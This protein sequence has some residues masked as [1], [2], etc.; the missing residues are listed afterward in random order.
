MTPAIPLQRLRIKRRS[1]AH[2]LARALGIIAG[3]VPPV[4]DGKAKNDGH[5][6]D[7]RSVN[8]GQEDGDFEGFFQAHEQAIFGYLWHITGDEQ[9]SYDLAQETFLRAWQRFDRVRRYE[10]PRAWLFRVATNLAS[11]HRRNRAMRQAA[12]AQVGMT[13]HA[14]V[15]PGTTVAAS[16]AVREALLA[17]PMKQRGALILRVVYGLSFAEIAQAFGTSEAAAKM[18]LA[19]G[20]ERFRAHYTQE[21]RR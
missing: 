16:D 20:R 3:K 9:T 6:V 10:Q 5:A 12:A 19:R 17:M 18:I 2:A 8:A 15:D 1:A 14:T 4:E 11:N 13:R 7:L 21:E